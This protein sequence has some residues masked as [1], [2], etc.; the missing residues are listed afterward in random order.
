MAV[1]RH[2]GVVTAH[3]PGEDEPLNLRLTIPGPADPSPYRI[4]AT[5]PFGEAAVV[6]DAISDALRRLA[7]PPE[8][9]VDWK[10]AALRLARCLIE[11]REL[12]EDV[13]ALDDVDIDHTVEAFGGTDVL[14][15]IEVRF[16]HE[17][18]QVAPAKG[19]V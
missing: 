5:V 11:I 9:W 1:L 10:A 14:R 16:S 8:G 17:M 12:S 6:A 19:R 3:R 7:T 13:D 15:L 18:E 4:E 2:V